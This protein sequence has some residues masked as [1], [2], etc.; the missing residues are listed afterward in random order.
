[1]LHP[2]TSGLV[3]CRVFGR[4][5]T[6]SWLLLLPIMALASPLAWLLAPSKTAVYAAAVEDKSA[7]AAKQTAKPAEDAATRKAE[8]ATAADVGDGRLIRVRLPLSGNDDS[9][10]KKAIERV[11]DQLGRSPKRNNRRPMLILE[12]V[13]QRSQAGNGEGTDFTRALSLADYLTRLSAVKTIAYIPR[14]IKGHGVL[15][16]LACDEIV[17]NPAAEIG[18]AGIDSDPVRAIDPKIISSYREIVASRRTVPEALALA[19]V[20]RRRG[21]IKVETDQG[22]DFK[23]QDEIEV[24]KKTHTIISQDTLVTVGSLGSFTGRQGWNFG[25]VKL[26]ASNVDALARGLGLPPDAIKQ[27]QLLLGEL[28]PVMVR[29]EGPVTRHKV[30]QL[31]TLIGAELRDHNVNWIGV[32]IDSEGGELDE[33]KELANIFADLNPDE[34]QTVAYVPVNAS[35]GAA[36]VALACDQL[37]MHPK[38]HLGGKGSVA[39][40]RA[41]IEDAREPLKK[42]AEK[43]TSHSWSLLAAMID[44]DIELIRFQNA[45]TGEVRYLSNEERTSLP[46]KDDWGQPVR[47]KAAGEPLR[48]TSD[49]AHEL[50]IATHVVD[51]FDELKQLYGFTEDVRMAEPNWALELVEALSSPALAVMLLVIG[52]VGI[53]IELHTPG[54]GVGGFVASVAFLLFFWSNFLHGTAGWL[55]VL[56]FVGGLLCL[57]LEVLV[58]PGFGIFGLGGGVMILASLVL[59]SQTFV[60]PR[61]ESQMAELRHSLTIVA[62]A[63]VIMVAAS[64]AL[65]RYLPKTPVFRTLLL[66][67]T[68]E[69]DLIDLDYRE[70]LADF[71][72]LVG[73]RGV[74]TTNLMPAGKAEFNGELVDVIA[75]G[76]PIDRGST[77]VVTKTRGNRVL[78]RAVDV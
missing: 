64:I 74:A 16:A 19:M 77:I 37:V 66:A 58:I 65:R 48:L 3:N 67:P 23:A 54:L 13:P 46:D 49:R 1:M 5:R 36:L 8:P 39:I 45:K 75:D 11:I 18:E 21:V 43:N 56:L 14:T 15:I 44:P 73:E 17:M 20:D 50:D 61:T 22:T 40:D 78:V 63:M 62:A 25:F 12:L 47:I 72:H 29:V 2:M 57:L 68:P 6:F 30:S 7:G 26:M 38:A 52:F 24:L 4:R 71:S 27:D 70:S 53:Y 32:T 76:M 69:E 35:G 31:R 42:L 33:C 41:M 10:I 28:R 55:E 9:H 60:L 59:A 34:V 51:N